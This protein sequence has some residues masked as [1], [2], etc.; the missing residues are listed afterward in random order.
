MKGCN[1]TLRGIKAMTHCESCGKDY[2]TTVFEKIC[3][4]CESDK[5]Y[6]L[7]GNEFNIVDISVTD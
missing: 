6:L 1:L 2:P 4:Y 5:T 3:P 7:T